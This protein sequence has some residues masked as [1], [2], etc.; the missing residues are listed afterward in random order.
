VAERYDAVVAGSGPA[1]TVAALE[2]ARGG[3]RTLLVDPSPFPR[4]KACGDLVGPRGV[5]LLREL[6]VEPARSRTVGDVV[7][8][9]PRGREL[10]LPWPTGRCFPPHVASI[11]RADLDAALRDAALAAGVEP[12]EGRVAEVD[13][14]RVLLSTGREL[15]ADAVVGADGAMSQ[16]AASADLVSPD[17]VLWGMAV[18]GYVD[19]EVELPLI[20]FWQPEPGRTLPGYGWLFP[21]PDGRANVGLG[22]GVAGDRPKAKVAAKLLPA[23]V[24]FLR[25]T[26]HLDGAPLDRST[27]R[28]GWL[29]MGMTGTVPAR[30]R[31]LLT[32]D[33]AGLVNPLQGE[34]ISEAMLSGRAAAEA[35][36]ADP[37]TAASSYA[38][39]LSTRFAGFHSVAAAIHAAVLHRP[40]AIGRLERALDVPVVGRAVAGGWAIWW[41]DLLSGARPGRARAVAASMAATA[42]LAMMSS[43]IRVQ[44]V[45]STSP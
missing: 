34:G 4:D 38:R 35:I 9:A 5:A 14:G 17:Q 45:A 12:C 25:A 28:G 36:L 3:A 13:D 2:L 24:A 20:V 32:G 37:A 19:A 22:L 33:A 31:V 43:P 29:K 21:G 16:V 7:V 41:N 27:W 30:G 6:G 40:A 8:V 26:G 11:P 39:D 42:A 1:G 23:F 10:R 15:R 44:V 18:R